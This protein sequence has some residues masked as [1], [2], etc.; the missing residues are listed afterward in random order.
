MILGVEAR[1]I[2]VGQKNLLVIP[3]MF[4]YTPMAPSIYTFSIIGAL[5]AAG[6]SNISRMRR[7][8]EVP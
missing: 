3:N 4:I 7:C 5:F 1:E 2:D 6:P 8:C